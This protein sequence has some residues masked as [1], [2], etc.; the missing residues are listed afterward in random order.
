MGKNL[1]SSLFWLG[2]A[3]F[4][5]A[6]SLTHKIGSLHAPGSGFL[7]FWAGVTLG[8]LSIVNLARSF[9]GKD[10]LV[11]FRGLQMGMVLTVMAGLLA[12]LLV[13][14]RLGFLL[15][16]FLLLLLLFKLQKKSWPFTGLFSLTVALASYTLFQVWLRSQLPKGLWGF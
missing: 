13:L 11:S 1:S 4:V 12:Y 15:A 8:L 9:G 10:D 3:L 14:E 7:P 16:T 5:C 2:F 6:A